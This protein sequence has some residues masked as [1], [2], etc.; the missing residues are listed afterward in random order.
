MLIATLLMIFGFSSQDAEQS[1]GISELVTEMIFGN[2]IEKQDMSQYEKIEIM[3]NIESVV[4]KL[5]HFGIY[6]IIGMILIGIHLTYGIKDKRKIIQTLI[7]GFVYATTDEIHQL[8]VPGRS[9]QISDIF[10]DF[11]GVLFGTYVIYILTKV[12]YRKKK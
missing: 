1:S 3:N 12:L 9:G 4:R 2:I 5:A 7:I 11:T 10:L 6:A 8:F